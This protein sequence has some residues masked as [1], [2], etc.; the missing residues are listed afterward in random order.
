METFTE[1][2]L[3]RNF[4][5]YFTAYLSIALS[6]ILSHSKTIK[7]AKKL[8]VFVKATL[9]VYLIFYKL[10]F[11][12]SLIIFLERLIKLITGIFDLQN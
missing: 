1:N 9:V 7:N 4:A 12:E 11:F 3:G 8:S 5:L 2:V 10:G 6:N